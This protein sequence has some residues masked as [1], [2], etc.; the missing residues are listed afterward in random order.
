MRRGGEGDRETSGRSEANTSNTIVTEG[1]PEK[2]T[3]Q[4]QRR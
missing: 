1:L 4:S 3:E 2:V